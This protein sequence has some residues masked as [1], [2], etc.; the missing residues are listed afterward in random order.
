M[1][2]TKI[3]PEQTARFGEWAR[4]WIEIGLSTE[5]ADFDKATEAA[6][7]GYKL[8]NLERPMIVLR[9]G[10]PFGACLGGALAWGFLREFSD[11][12]TRAKL[13]S[14]VWSQVGSQ[15]W[16]QVRSQ[17]WSQVE[18]QVRSAAYNNSYMGQLWGA[19][20]N[21][22]VTFFRDVM[23]WQDPVLERH[24]I[25]ETLAKTCG[26][27]WWHE[28][29]LAISDRP[30]FLNRDESG[31]LHA[32]TGPSI[33]YRDGWALHHWHGV[34]VE[35]WIIEQPALITVEKIESE[36]NAEIRRVMVERYGEDRYIIDSGLKPIAQD[37]FGELFRKD[38]SGDTPLVYV[39][40]RNSTAEPDGHFKDYFLS[41]NPDHYD[42][43]AGRVPH[44]AIAS[45]WR[46]TSTG[47]TL[48]FKRYEDYRLSAES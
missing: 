5:P 46:T 32:E 17:V 28:N 6:L 35:P 4:K 12:K 43:A 11:K 39:K 16:S 23:G 7:R 45:T 22:Y 25:D 1:K 44:A 30:E 13:G 48:F 33:K 42:G 47:E 2:I 3:T 18:S 19:G 31:R 26:W 38:F 37:A 8:A 34:F 27:T 14:Q 21:A 9:M 24:E 41:V 29:V 15:V 36:G 20:W 40:V 10:S